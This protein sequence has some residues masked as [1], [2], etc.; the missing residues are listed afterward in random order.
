[1]ATPKPVF[2]LG[3]GAQKA[4]TTWVYSYLRRHPDCAMS[5]EKEL[6]FFNILFSEPDFPTARAVR[7][8]RL[9]SMANRQLKQIEAG[10]TGKGAVQFVALMDSI[11]MQF[12]PDRYIRYFDQ[13]RIENPTATV[14]GDIT[15]LYSGL[16]AENFHTIRDWIVEAGYRPRVV[17]LMRDPVERCYSAIRMADRNRKD[18]GKPILRPARDRFAKEAVSR[19]CEI[20]TRYEHTIPALE[21]AFPKD[22]LF[23]GIFEDFF[24]TEVARDLCDFLD[25][26]FVD[27]NFDHIAN[28]SPRDN[29]PR[30]EDVAKVQAFY[31]ETYAFCRNRFGAERIDRLW[32]SS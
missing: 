3:V 11:A 12:Q 24:R 16:K 15:P 18:S 5:P 6:G 21:K 7:L 20:R 19:W 30:P 25:I 4:G 26:R 14:F 1:M 23:Y 2:I 13:M 32:P 27:P 22:E 31:A 28:A 8:Q 9:I 17:F 29:A 10:K